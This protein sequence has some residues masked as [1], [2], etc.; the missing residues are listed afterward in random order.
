MKKISLDVETLK[1][2]TFAT[3]PEP[4]VTRGTVEAH[5][6][7]GCGTTTCATRLYGTL[8]CATCEAASC[9]ETCTNPYKTQC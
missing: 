8:P 5:A 6:T 1:V 9:A 7:P 3:E 4:D 2:T